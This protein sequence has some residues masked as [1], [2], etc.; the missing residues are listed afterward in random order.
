MEKNSRESLLR[1]GMSHIPIATVH[2]FKCIYKFK[3][4]TAEVIGLH[5]HAIIRMTYNL[6][7][8]FF[9]YEY[10]RLLRLNTTIWLVLHNQ[11]CRYYSSPLL[12]G[13]RGCFNAF[14]DTTLITRH[15]VFSSVRHSDTTLFR[16]LL[17]LGYGFN[18]KRK[19]KVKKKI[20]F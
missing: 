18:N 2:F 10:S 17:L 14:G 12:E 7:I 13:T 6:S 4:S 15:N 11:C 3:A 1:Q 5:F 19:V 8:G 20:N 9:L 16:T